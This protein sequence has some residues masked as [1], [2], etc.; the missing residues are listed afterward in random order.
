[1]RPFISLSLCAL[2]ACGPKDSDSATAAG[3]EE[4]S[5]AMTTGSP[6]ATEAAMT[7]TGTPTTSGSEATTSGSA[8]TTSGAG[9]TTGDA[10][11]EALAAAKAFVEEHIACVEDA[12][13]RGYDAFCFPGGACG[14]VGVNKDADPATAKELFSALDLACQPCGADP[15]GAKSV[16]VAKR[17]ETQI[18]L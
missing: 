15:C 13:C 4:T 17:C 14:L 8:A 7:E 3:S 10:C 18:D 12:D 9:G 6:P 16:C 2:V 11:E 1:M 5:M